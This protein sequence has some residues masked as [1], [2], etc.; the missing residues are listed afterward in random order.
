[1]FENRKRIKLLFFVTEDWY[2]VSHRLPLAIAAKNIGYDVCVVT[3]V[4]EHGAAISSAGIRL[5]PFENVRGSLNP[6]KGFLTLTRL[7][8]VYW[9][10]RPQIV[11]NIAMTPVIY[12]TIAAHCAPVGSVINALAGLGHVF[13][14]KDRKSTTLR[15]IVE[16]AFRLLFRSSN[17]CVIV[18]NK[19][20]RR[21]LEKIGVAP[22]KIVLIEG[23]GVDLNK[24]APG[25]EPLGPVVVT[26]VSRMLWPKGV[27]ELVE[28]ARI[29][30]EGGRDIRVILIGGPDPANPLSVDE[31][32]LKDWSRDGL[33][34][35]LGF[36]PREKIPSIWNHA[37]IGVLPSYYGEGIPKSLL[38]AA[39]SGKALI[40]TDMPGCRDVVIHEQTGLLVPPRNSQALAEAISRLAK[41]PALRARLGKAARARVEERFSVERVVEQTLSLYRSIQPVN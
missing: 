10:E 19:A 1:M 33:I 29:L 13:T 9:R 7:I 5:V 12:G 4:R 27:G 38:E 16:R 3:R 32:T 39:A 31:A 17:V 28:A 2:F 36:V 34:E 23:S 37:H 30:G 14:S 35:W 11:H 41:D 24:F 15:N 22:T 18:Q 26:M 8:V 25:P 6:F 40:A 21:A 20:D